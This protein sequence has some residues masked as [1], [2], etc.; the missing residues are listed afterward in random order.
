MSQIGTPKSATRSSSNIYTVLA[1]I[2]FLSL[3]TAV[4]Y[5]GY[6]NAQLTGD[7]QNKSL[8]NPFGLVT[9]PVRR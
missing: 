6:K 3:L 4:C 8:G 7:P 5:V 2:A 1:L 9:T